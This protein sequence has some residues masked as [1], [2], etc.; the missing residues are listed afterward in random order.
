[1]NGPRSIPARYVRHVAIALV[2]VV[3]LG[4][5][6]EL[7][8]DVAYSRAAADTLQRKIEQIWG[9][10]PGAGHRSKLPPVTEREVNA[11]LRFQLRDQVPA[12]IAEP[13]ITI[14]GNGR[15]S[16]RSV[17]DLDEVSRASRSSSWLDPM[18]LL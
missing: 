10:P 3:T 4:A 1:M 11:Y 16:G 9:L 5:H 7:S 2:S 18:R 17:V 15:V 14:V 12:G 13:V 8:A 6:G